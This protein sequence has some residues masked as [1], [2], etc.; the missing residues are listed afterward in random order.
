LAKREGVSVVTE[1]GGHGIGR[2]MH[3]EPHISHVGSRG[4]GPRLKTGMALTVEP[5]V[6]LG[7][8]AVRFLDDDWTV[9]TADGSLSAQWEHTVLVTPDGYEIIT[10]P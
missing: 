3:S 10:L 1:F 7:G 2:K 6:N 8:P 9:V 5:M 4:S